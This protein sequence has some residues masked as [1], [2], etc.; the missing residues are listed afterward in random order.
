M[1]LCVWPWWLGLRSRPEL[2]GCRGGGGRRGRGL[3]CALRSPHSGL[4]EPLSQ[5]L[6]IL[7]NIVLYAIGPGP[8]EAGEGPEREEEGA[9][10]T[11]APG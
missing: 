2:G 5:V 10:M 8:H 1:M 6:L 9:M 3:G 7:P 11:G 4:V